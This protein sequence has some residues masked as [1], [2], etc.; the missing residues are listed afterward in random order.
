MTNMKTI[1]REYETMIFSITY[2]KK[3]CEENEPYGFMGDYE[4]YIE[5]R[6]CIYMFS[7][8]IINKIT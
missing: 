2:V 4:L 8:L 1:Q 6:L 7:P 5:G 3:V